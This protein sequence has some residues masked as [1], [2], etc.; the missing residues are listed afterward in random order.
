MSDFDEAR[1]GEW[2]CYL[3]HF[4]GRLGNPEGIGYAMHYLGTTHCLWLRL[5]MHERGRGAAITAAAAEVGITWELARTWRGGR[6]VERRLKGRPSGSRGFREMCPICHPMPRIVQFPHLSIR[7]RG[8]L[9][10]D[11]WR[12]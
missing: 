12:T 4:H 2:V 6:Q 5:K 10:D 9:L 3:L 7:T 1:W 11:P 8:M